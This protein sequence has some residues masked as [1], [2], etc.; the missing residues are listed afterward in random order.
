MCFFALRVFFVYL[1][2]QVLMLESN[3]A[4]RATKIKIIVMS[5]SAFKP[6][7]AVGF[8]SNILVL[9]EK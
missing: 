9:L 8:I 6:D 4:Q 2:A 5:M 7:V 1:A 3:V